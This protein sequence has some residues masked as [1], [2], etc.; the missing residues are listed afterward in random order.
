M[1]KDI[2]FTDD[3]MHTAAL[4]AKPN[5]KI[6]KEKDYIPIDKQPVRLNSEGACQEFEACGRQYQRREMIM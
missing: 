5:R 3:C 2:A 4:T 1:R 6:K